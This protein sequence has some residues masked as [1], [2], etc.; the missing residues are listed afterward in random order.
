VKE[1]NMLDWINYRKALLGRTGEFGKLSP[2]TLKGYQTLS[3]AGAAT[4][5]LDAKTREL[6]SIA[7]AVTSRCDG[8]ITIHTSEAIRLGATKEEIAETLGVAGAINAGA[9]MV[10]SA[11][12]L[13]AVEAH[14][15][16]AAKT[17]A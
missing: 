7:V 2:D 13:D 3:K 9:A 17:G 14:L 11:R 6:I 5:F 10:Y 4:N 8:C 16:A 1:T 12:T 15:A